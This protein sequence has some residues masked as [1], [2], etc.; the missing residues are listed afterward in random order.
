LEPPLQLRSERNVDPVVLPELHG[1]DV[2][3]RE[4]QK[5]EEDHAHPEVEAE[6][7]DVPTSLSFRVRQGEGTRLEEQRPEGPPELSLQQDRGTDCI[8]HQLPE[9]PVLGLVLLP[10]G[11][12]VRPEHA[13]AAVQAMI[14]K[15]FPAPR[16]APGFFILPSFSRGLHRKPRIAHPVRAPAA[17]G[18]GS[19]RPTPRR[20]A[21]PTR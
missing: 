2:R 1:H 5:G 9:A 13:R 19:L 21:G 17:P 14:G 3:R 15:P 10:T 18:L 7:P 8:L 12:A 16:I 4:G 6:R 20:P 11:G